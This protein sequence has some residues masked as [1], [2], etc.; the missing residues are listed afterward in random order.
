MFP[1]K[2]LEI[3]RKNLSFFLIDDFSY[4]NLHDFVSPG[5]NLKSQNKIF[6]FVANTTSPCPLFVVFKEVSFFV[7]IDSGFSCNVELQ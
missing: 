7:E 2:E 6:G 5:A 4:K 1:C 3:K